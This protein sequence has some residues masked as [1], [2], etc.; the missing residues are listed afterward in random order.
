MVPQNFAELM[1]PGDPNDPLL[2]QVLPLGAEHMPAPGF[3]LDPVGDAAAEKAPGLLQKY[4]GRALL[5]VTGAC[6]VHCRYCF[7]RHFPY[8]DLGPTQPRLDSALASLAA[9]RSIQEVILSGGDPLM[10]DDNQIA[11]L[12][13]RLAQVPHL[14]RLRIH[15]RLPIVLPARV[16]EHLAHVLAESR[17]ATVVVIHAN[18][19]RELG[20]AAEQALSRLAAQGARLLNQ[21]VLLRR[22]NDDVVT[23]QALSERLLDCRVLPYYIHQLDPV[24]G[25]AHF[26]VSDKCAT[27]LI[28]QLRAR[29]SG[30][31]VPK[32][33][34][35]I[36]GQQSKTQ[37]A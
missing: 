1:R 9:D 11:A 34:R 13:N 31:L 29:T 10:L 6:A 18:H 8:R 17:L 15:T 24:Q 19:P 20:F 26:Q 37:I 16:T 35:E 28:N 23:L 5:M 12:I 36:S 4:A 22:V 7:R 21:S 25:A 27:M 14:R 30:Y 2:R 32:L 3:T 33:V